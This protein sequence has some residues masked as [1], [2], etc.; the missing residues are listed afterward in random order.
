MTGPGRDVRT[1]LLAGSTDEF[2]AMRQDLTDV[3]QPSHHSSPPSGFVVGT[4]Q[5]TTI[6][7]ALGQLGSEG[8]ATIVAE[9]VALFRP[10]AVLV[11]GVAES[12]RPE[13]V[14]GDVMVA[15]RIE[16]FTA[17]R[18]G[19]R[20]LAA[21]NS[22][23]D[24]LTRARGLKGFNSSDTS[25]SGYKVKP[26][27]V[28]FGTVAAVQDLMALTPPPTRDFGEASV[29]GTERLG[30]VWRSD[31]P[32]LP[33][34][35]IYGVQAQHVDGRTWS[36]G[37]LGSRSMSPPV[38]NSA[39]FALGLAVT[40][41]E[42]HHEIGRLRTMGH[43][44]RIAHRDLLARDAFV[45][46]LAELL[47]HSPAPGT[48]QDLAGPTVIAIEGAWG[49]GKS[50]LMSLTRARL[51]SIEPDP[52]PRRWWNGVVARWRRRRLRVWEADF[53]LNGWFTRSSRQ[54]ES[55]AG[56]V[57]TAL[58]NPWSYLTGEHV[59][60]GLNECIV[61]AVIAGDADAVKRF[62]FVHNVER[63]DRQHVQRTLRKR[64]V[65]PVLRLA[66]FAL[67]VPLLAQLV[68]TTTPYSVLGHVV[69][70]VDL[71]LWVTALLLAAGFVHT[72]V[73]YVFRRAD[74]VLPAELF[75]PSGTLHAVAGGAD[76]PMRDPH[77]RLRTGLLHSVQQD[78]HGLLRRLD[79]GNRQLVVFIDD[80]DRCSPRTTADVLEAINGFLTDSFP[81]IRFVLGIDAAATAAHLD[82]AYSALAAAD[83]G[84]DP[85]DP[86]A[87]WTFLRKLVQLPLPLPRVVQA[88]VD[89]LLNGLLGTHPA[90]VLDDPGTGAAAARPSEEQPSPA[91]PPADA[92]LV[93]E[94]RTAP[95][96]VALEHDEQDGVDVL[97]PGA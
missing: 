24:L 55:A 21:W 74:R 4:V 85:A 41:H 36:S 51:E 72:A 9:A 49:A 32:E 40:L 73:R 2:L 78:V 20:R 47:A 77:R 61:S 42:S 66:V 82:A 90:T 18:R 68:R 53:A 8:T 23:T 16:Y 10:V 15:T 71:A 65:S 60:A 88:H 33:I 57:L 26:F 95:P 11:V 44:D 19:V 52:R 67:P 63:L 69:Q 25:A 59:L 92:A 81:T 48:D 91:T 96:L 62:W 93:E 3:H 76:D 6:Q 84:R 34:L 37:G 58:F 97:R 45:D 83:A 17:E 87:G 14:P 13:V 64:I 54:H 30:P 80:L 5:D 50:T 89:P 12:L 75:G 22:R 43:G 28:H 7:V 29:I 86:S 94:V 39:L 27:T 79:A 70:P 1:V 46:S 35:M 38:V 56:P 31:N